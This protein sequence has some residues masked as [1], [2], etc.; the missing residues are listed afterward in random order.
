MIR[1]FLSNTV[2]NMHNGE[3][4]RVLAEFQLTDSLHHHQPSA[5][6]AVRAI[7]RFHLDQA[8]QQYSSSSQTNS[9]HHCCHWPSPPPAAPVQLA[10]FPAF[11]P[12]CDGGSRSCRVGPT[13]AAVH[14]KCAGGVLWLAAA[15]MMI[16]PT[17]QRRWR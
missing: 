4:N 9:H 6:T 8:H 16:G 15:N 12:R 5:A 7:H 2:P 17:F 1:R 14:C 13:S 11:H 3:K 10:P